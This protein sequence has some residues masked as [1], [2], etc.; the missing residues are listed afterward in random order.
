MGETH[1]MKANQTALVLPTVWDGTLPPAA[2]ESWQFPQVQRLP[3]SLALLE[4][5]KG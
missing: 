4:D 1:Q 3:I 2:P 5:L